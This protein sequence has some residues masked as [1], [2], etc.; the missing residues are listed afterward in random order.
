MI[1]VAIR[2]NKEEQQREII[3]KLDEVVEW[4]NAQDKKEEV[5]EG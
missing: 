1:K 5:K 4:I 2:E 3:E